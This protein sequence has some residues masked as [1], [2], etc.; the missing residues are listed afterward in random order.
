MK[1]VLTTLC[2]FIV[3]A[4]FAQTNY[5]VEKFANT[6]TQKDL[7]QHL[8]Y[9]AGNET[10]GRETATVGQRKA[11]LY[12]EEQFKNLGL[13]PGNANSFYQYFKVYQDV[14][15]SSSLKIYDAHFS[16]NNHY[17]I[18]PNST[19]NGSISINQIVFASY[20]LTDKTMNNYENI[21][22]KGKWVMII[23][24]NPEDI[25]KEKSGADS[26]KSFT[27]IKT[28]LDKGAI[29]VLLVSKNFDNPKYSTL[30]I[31]GSMYVKKQS[32]NLSTPIISISYQAAA[33]ILTKTI[34]NF[35]DLKNIETGTKQTKTVKQDV[36]QDV[37]I[38]SAKDYTV[39]SSEDLKNKVS[40]VEVY[41]NPDLFVCIAKASSKS[42]RWMKSTKV[43]EVPGGCVLQVT[44]QQDDNI[45]EAVTFVPGTMLEK[46]TN[47]NYK[48]V[49][50]RRAN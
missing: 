37:K 16:L 34:V 21:D 10:E 38:G 33:S 17:T 27:K 45:A 42:G 41:G 4:T 28:A 39:V 11:A 46:D 47:G 13:K 36:K 44:T 40:D 50:Y 20:G 48:L 29:G 12:I 6:I 24:S 9:I 43:M 1:I 49:Q 26:R 35:S 14:L 32:N 7:K 25:D 5:N 15:H 2:Y 18:Q 22:I 3:A 23:E 19:S 31:T 30:P 8:T